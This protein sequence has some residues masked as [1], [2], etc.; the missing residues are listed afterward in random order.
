[1]LVAQI[2]IRHKEIAHV[3]SL[4][5]D[6]PRRAIGLT[7]LDCLAGLLDLLEDGFVGERVFSDDV[8]GLVLEGYVVRLDACVELIATFAT[9]RGVHPP[10]SF[11][12]TR[13][14]APEQPP[15]LMAMLN[16]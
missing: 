9:N 3:D 14:T 2:T 8:G 1:M 10:S 12:S 7:G 15:Q 16:L 11:L 6:V 13:S 5:L 4:S